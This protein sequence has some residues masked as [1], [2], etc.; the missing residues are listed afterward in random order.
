MHI[1]CSHQCTGTC[2]SF[3]IIVHSK[4]CTYMRS[5]TCVP[6]PQYRVLYYSTGYST[7]VPGTLLQYRVHV[8][9][10]TCSTC[11]GSTCLCLRY[12]SLIPVPRKEQLM[13]QQTLTLMEDDHICLLFTTSTRTSCGTCTWTRTNLS[14]IVPGATKI[15]VITA[16]GGQHAFIQCHVA[17]VCSCS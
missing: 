6:V 10:G 17:H 16:N 3:Y 1:Y 9:P 2:S 4:H 5:F 7:T 8:V 13:P 11:T 12:M 15:F 14:R